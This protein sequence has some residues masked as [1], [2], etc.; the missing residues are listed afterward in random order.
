MWNQAR[1]PGS[2]FPLSQLADEAL[3]GKEPCSGSLST[4]QPR[5]FHMCVGL[6]CPS[7][8]SQAYMHPV[9]SLSH[10]YQLILRAAD[11]VGSK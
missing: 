11:S 7:P 2:S 6:R 9:A 10:R 3:R 4:A 5:G 8:P 1:T